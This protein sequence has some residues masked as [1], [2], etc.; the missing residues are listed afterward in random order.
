MDMLTESLES[1]VKLML[2]ILI[3]RKLLTKYHIQN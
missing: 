2:F 1:G 3:W